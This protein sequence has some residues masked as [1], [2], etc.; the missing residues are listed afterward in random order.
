MGPLLCY[1]V[2]QVNET[3][4]RGKK[5]QW[6]ILGVDSSKSHTNTHTDTHTGKPLPKLLT[7]TL[8]VSSLECPQGWSM[9][10]GDAWGPAQSLPQLVSNNRLASGGE[11]GPR[12]LGRRGTIS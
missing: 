9:R 8:R 5:S 10:C 2:A 4:I 11:A 1:Q 7:C 12:D 3:V 6:L